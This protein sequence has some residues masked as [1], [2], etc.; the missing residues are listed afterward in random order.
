MTVKHCSD[1]TVLFIDNKHLFLHHHAAV[2]FPMSGGKTD[3]PGH[4]PPQIHIES[5]SSVNLCPVFFYT[6]AYL[7]CTEHLGQSQM[8]HV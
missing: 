1:L 5:H 6:K 2:F 7:R 3:C 8:D 4:R